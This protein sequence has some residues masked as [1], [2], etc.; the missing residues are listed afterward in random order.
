M[1]NFEELMK[2]YREWREVGEDAIIGSDLTFT[3]D[4]GEGSAREDFTEYAELEEEITFELMKELE[5]CY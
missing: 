4:C 3:W 2:L 5:D 1:K